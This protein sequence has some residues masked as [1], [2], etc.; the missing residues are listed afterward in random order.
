VSDVDG[1]LVGVR[2]TQGQCMGHWEFYGAEVRS[3]LYALESASVSPRHALLVGVV[4]YVL[5]SFSHSFR[6]ADHAAQFP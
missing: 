3:K 5:S 4:G 6:Y 2:V 1:Q